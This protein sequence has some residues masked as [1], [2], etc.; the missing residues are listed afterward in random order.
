MATPSL[1]T[2]YQDNRFNPVPIAL[3]TS[4]D[5][6]AH[7]AKR[8]NLYERHLGIP[9]SLL[10]GRS[11]LEF[12]P[13]S[14]ENALILASVGAN[15]T[16]VEPNEQVLP[17]IRSLFSRFGL[18]ER[19]ISLLHAGIDAFESENLYDLVLAEGF[20]YTLPNRDELIKKIINL[21]VPGGLT[22]I[23]FNDRYGILIEL[24]R[25]MVLW[26]ACQL[27]GLED[28]H[29]QAALDLAEQLYGADFAK[30]N[31]SRP[32]AAWWKDTLVNPLLTSPYLWSYWELIPLIESLNCDFHAGSPR[33]DS[34][35]HFDWY[36]NVP[37]RQERHQRLLDNWGKVFPYILTGLRLP[38]IV[39]GP[40]APETISAVANL[41]EQIS[42][43][44]T[45]LNASIKM[46]SYP[47][48]LD[49]YLQQ[50][51]VSPLVSFNSEMKHLYYV[52]QS[53]HLGDLIAAYHSA[54]T[55]RNLWGTPYHYICFSKTI[56]LK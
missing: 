41:I 4:R 15:L 52:A 53:G 55:V 43:Y 28:F 27:A 51:N 20:L 17:G 1:L 44:T 6:Q 35:E 33:W 16:L 8:R 11:V 29:G 31:A 48:L 56:I 47:A 26:R 24:T 38:N 13:N 14:G 18:E 3:D 30:L 32:F 22:V 12:G 2:Y 46:V 23:S 10:Q 19:I 5:W 39:L 50:T 37:T 21:L 7:F 40:T 42:V 45:N 9:L 34:L 25:R 54:K 49:E 36:K